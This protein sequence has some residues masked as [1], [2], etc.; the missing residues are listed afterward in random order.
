MLAVGVIPARLSSSR[1]PGKVLADV[2]GRPLLWHV[3]RRLQRVRCLAQVYVVTDSETIQAHVEEWGGTVILTSPNCSCG[4]DR[5]AAALPQLAGDFIVNVQADE[6]LVEPDLLESLVNAAGDSGCDLVTPIFRIQRPE[7]LFCPALVKVVRG[8]DGR[9]LYFS[10]SAI[11]YVR[12]V[13]ADRWLQE[14]CYWGH[15]GIY[16]YKRAVVAAFPRLPPSPL[17]EAERLEQLRFLDAGFRI[18]TVETTC[19]R[20]AVDT[21]ADLE[22]I[23]AVL[24][25]GD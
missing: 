20:A 3:W 23:R 11:P 25:G 7:D 1:L 16:V 24:K 10:R 5:I 13:A 17:E 12:D 15:L 6:P 18:H 21:A 22:R 14:H 8:Q 9:A 4:T 19:S 2:G